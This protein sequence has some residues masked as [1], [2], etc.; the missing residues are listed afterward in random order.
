MALVF[1]LLQDAAIEVEPG[2]L[3]I[4]ESLRAGG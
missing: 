3:P 1:G 2:K 4:D